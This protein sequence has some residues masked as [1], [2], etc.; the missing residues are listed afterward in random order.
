MK[1][2][3]IQIKPGHESTGFTLIELLVVVAI[4]AVLMALLLPALAN[5][6]L[7]AKAAK[8]SANQKTIGLAMIGFSTENNNRLP[9][10]AV[11]TVGGGMQWFTILNAEFFGNGKMSTSDSQQMIQ[12]QYGDSGAGGTKS[13]QFAR[14]LYCPLF[15]PSSTSVLRCYQYNWDACGMDVSWRRKY[16]LLISDEEATQRSG[17]YSTTGTPSTTFFKPG[18]IDPTGSNTAGYFLGAKY[19]VFNPG[20]IM[21]SEGYKAIDQVQPAAPNGYLF[22]D[23]PP[24]PTGSYGSNGTNTTAVNFNAGMFM[25]R[26]NREGT[27]ATFLFFDGHAESVTPHDEYNT[28]NKLRVVNN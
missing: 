4:I 25:F 5:A 16:G 8:C 15:I 7:L 27:R 22:P 21:M 2:R 14:T 17:Y 19:S 3:A 1:N 6:R 24:A 12:T 13:G 20:Q 9:G 26:H 28:I 18:V 11:K 23:N 10:Y